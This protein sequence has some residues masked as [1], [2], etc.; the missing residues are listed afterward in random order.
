M[1]IFVW[2]LGTRTGRSRSLLGQYH[3]HSEISASVARSASG[4][5]INAHRSC[6]ND[7]DVVGVRLQRIQGDVCPHMSSLRCDTGQGVLTLADEEA[8]AYSREVEAVEPVLDVEVDIPRV[9]TAFPLED[10]LRDG[11]DGGV[12]SP[13]DVLERLGEFAV[14]L[15]HLGRPVDL[16]RIRVVSAEPVSIVL[17][18]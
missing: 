8:D 18:V 13:L 11:G 17:P 15:L 5:S 4:C 7:P 9:L 12:V 6:A 16:D 10:A 2:P 1:I 3:E 14:E